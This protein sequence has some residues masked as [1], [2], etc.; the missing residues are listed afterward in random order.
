M[1]ALFFPFDGWLISVSMASSQWRQTHG[2]L[3]LP[4]GRYLHCVDTCH[5]VIGQ[6]N[7]YISWGCHKGAKRRMLS[8]SQPKYCTEDIYCMVCI[9]KS[10][11][12]HVPSE[13]ADFK[14][15]HLEICEKRFG[16]QGATA[17][18]ANINFCRKFCLQKMY[19]YTINQCK[20]YYIKSQVTL[21]KQS[22]GDHSNKAV[23]LNGSHIT[24]AQ[25]SGI[26]RDDCQAL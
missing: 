22:L 6:I 12:Q 19:E 20:H 2:I 3:A 15:L 24:L 23:H 14:G 25:I 4:S 1:D 26:L 11:L 7:N 17:K 9:M 8:Y 10:Y 16:V 18:I 21:I 5:I 13:R